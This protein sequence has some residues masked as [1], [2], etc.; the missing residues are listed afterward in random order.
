MKYDGTA[1][2]EEKISGCEVNK[3]GAYFYQRIRN[4]NTKPPNKK[5]L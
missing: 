3:V 1:A 2:G 4:E 5:M